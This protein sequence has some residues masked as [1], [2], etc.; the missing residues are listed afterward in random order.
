MQKVLSAAL[1]LVAPARER[2]H[3]RRVCS[4]VLATSATV[5]PFPCP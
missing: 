2:S 5:S 3:H 4:I 1:L